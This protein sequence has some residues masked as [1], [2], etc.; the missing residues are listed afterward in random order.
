MVAREVAS[1]GLAVTVAGRDQRQAEKLARILGP[2]CSALAADVSDA[3]A[4]RRALR[5]QAVAVNCAGSLDRLGPGLLDACLAAGCHYADIAVERANLA[6][7]RSR[8]EEFRRRGLVAAYGCSSLPAVSGALALLAHEGRQDPPER[9]RVTLFIGNDNPKGPAAVRSFLDILGKEIAA[10]QGTLWGFR[11]GEVVTLPAPFGRRR[12]YNFDSP[13]Y[14]LFPSL[15]G[16]K[17]VAVKV[18]F[19]LRLATYAFA[20]LAR[21]GFRPGARSAS[22]ISWGGGALRW[23]GCSGGAVMAELFYADG[24]ISRA[25][26]LARRDGQRM[27][28]LPCALVTR[29]LT[30]SQ[31][32]PVGSLTAYELLGAQQ[33]LHE[34][35]KRRFTLRFSKG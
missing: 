23:L 3:A 1:E 21:I 9:A 15:L 13:E 10:P 14:D 12:V 26:L 8:S 19:E 11:Q 29:E 31:S 2:A 35:S 32:H 28:I 20:L 18:G 25:S 16:V 5:G 4:C 33:L 30:R 24:L 27:A 22:L 6:Q 17:A 7:V 34:M